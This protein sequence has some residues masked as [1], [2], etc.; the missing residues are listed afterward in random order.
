MAKQNSCKHRI[1]LHINDFSS[2][3][4]S[5]ERL[6][7][8]Y[9]SHHLYIPSTL[10]KNGCHLVNQFKMLGFENITEIVGPKGLISVYD[11]FRVVPYLKETSF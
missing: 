9:R 2:K 5:D 11:L 1:S 10:E 3:L 8:Y 4:K 7:R 6:R